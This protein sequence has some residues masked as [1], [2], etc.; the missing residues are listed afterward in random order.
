MVKINQTFLY[1]I[2]FLIIVFLIEYT[3]FK[4]V[5]LVITN[6]EESFNFKNFLIF[7][8]L[9]KI[10]GYIIKIL[11]LL[12][13]FKFVL[14]A[15]DIKDDI[16]IFKTLI[17]SE[18]VYLFAVKG[19]LIIYFFF[20]DNDIDATF[21]TNFESSVSLKLFFSETITNSALKHL[22]AFTTLFDILYISVIVL[23]F[24]HD[25]KHSFLEVF[26]KIGISYL[27][28]LLFISVVKTLMAM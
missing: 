15:F 11:L 20:I 3:Y 28:L 26:K 12:G 18:I 9:F 2:I 27:M 19:F 7:N 13:F 25:L 5:Y 21:L 6:K 14:F 4:D 23:L 22:L 17:I 8:L 24:S 16:S 1:L 10:I